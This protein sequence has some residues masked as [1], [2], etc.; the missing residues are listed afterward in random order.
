[1]GWQGTPL[2]IIT[3]RERGTLKQEFRSL[4]NKAPSAKWD[5]VNPVEFGSRRKGSSKLLETLL[6]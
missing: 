2:A 1:L 6:F 3:D 5:S 4:A